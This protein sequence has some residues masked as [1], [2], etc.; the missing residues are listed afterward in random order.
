MSTRTVLKLGYKQQSQVKFA[1]LPL[2]ENWEK[3]FIPALLPSHSALYTVGM[4]QWTSL[5][6]CSEYHYKPVISV[7][8]FTF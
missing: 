4:F 5:Q 1:K 6:I 7:I 2:G 8:Q 3:I